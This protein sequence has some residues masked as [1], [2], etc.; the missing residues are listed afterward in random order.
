MQM[1]PFRASIS[2]REPSSLETYTQVNWLCDTKE[3]QLECV[4][5]PFTFINKI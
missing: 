5:C 3:E 2:I 1:C 4:E